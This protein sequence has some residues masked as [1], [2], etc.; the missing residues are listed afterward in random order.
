MRT[1]AQ[2]QN[3]PQKAV[4]S[5]L[6]LIQ[7]KLAIGHINDPLEHEADR[8]ADQVMQMSAPDPSI[9]NTTLQLSRKR[10]DGETEEE[11]QIPQIKSATTSEPASRSAPGIVP[12][13]LH[14][15]GQPLEA[16]TRTY[17][18]PRFGHD[19][20]RVR[21]HLN[22]DAARS[23]KAINALAYTV[24]TDIVFGRG[25][26]R[27]ETQVGRHLLAHELAHVVQSGDS[28]AVVR[29][30]PQPRDATSNS[31]RV[32]TKQL[33]KGSM[34]WLV[35]L[36]D[37]ERTA[38]GKDPKV[39]EEVGD[40][41]WATVQLRFKPNRSFGSKMV[42]FLQT[43]LVVKEGSTAVL[44]WLAGIS[45]QKPQLDVSTNKSDPFYGASFVSKGQKWEP[46]DAPEGFKNAP[47][48]AVDSSAWLFDEPTANQ[49][50]VKL[51]ESV[52]VVPETGE[53][54]G[55][56]R[57]GISDGA[58]WGAEDKDCT[59]APSADFRS[60]VESFYATPKSMEAQ[61]RERYD[62]IVDGFIANDGVPATG[63]R[64][65]VFSPLQ[66]AATLTA[67]QETKL[68]PVIAWYKS[69]V[70]NNVK[71]KVML[72]GFADPTETDPLGTSD[73]RARAVKNYLVS[74]GVPDSIIIALPFAAAWALY[75]PSVKE[76]RNR[77]VQLQHFIL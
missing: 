28:P 4:S 12:E 75:P 23:T 38:T 53:T 56:L 18:E 74:L 45:G 66:K 47:S 22:E 65:V 31:S 17:F 20:S 59:D 63:P 40:V 39:R 19:F 60:A 48:G 7:T 49:G 42:T 37:A 35:M 16:S 14:S 52:A 2:K 44:G 10:L 46:E 27:P 72:A 15:P 33:S 76:G 9:G 51:F 11:V 57:W 5:S 70:N 1:F 36:T 29:R 13:V 50:T 67:D 61:G 26:Y 71:F 6:P 3:R 64:G 25:L 30:Q 73:Q 58:V 68:D 43:K 41:Q 34:E 32:G 21:V 62:A 77:R 24:G 8:V 69:L 55:A 54:L